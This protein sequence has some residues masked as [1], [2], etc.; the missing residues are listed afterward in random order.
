MQLS[1][2][3]SGVLLST[4]GARLPNRTCAGRVRDAPFTGL[5]LNCHTAHIFAARECNIYE[6]EYLFLLIFM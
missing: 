3:R 2:N 6:N 5:S 1:D 4:A